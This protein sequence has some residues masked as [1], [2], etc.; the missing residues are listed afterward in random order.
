MFRA[1]A[2][3]ACV[4]AWT[5]PAWAQPAPAPAPDPVATLLKRVEQILNS[6]DR[7]SFPSLF[8]GLSDELIAQHAFDL[9]MPGAVRT[10]VHE[11]DRTDLEGAP[12]GDGYRVVVELFIETPRRAKIVTAGLDIRRP[13]GGDLNSWRIVRTEGVASVEGLFRLRLITTT[14]YAARNLEVRAEDL[15]ITLQ[16]G[17]VFQVDTEEGITGLILLGRGEMRFSPTPET[18]RGQLRIFSG[19]ETLT[20]PFEAAFLRL[21]PT[22]YARLVTTSALTT[23]MPDARMVRRAQ[24]VFA[25]DSPKSYVLG[26]QD[27]S[28]DT[29]HLQPPANDMLVEVQ[30]RRYGILTYTR[31]NAQAEDVQLFQRERRRTIALYASQAKL[32]ARGRFYSDDALREYDVIDYNIEAIVDPERQSLEARARLAIRARASISTLTLRLA[33][34]LDVTSVTSVE[35]GR[36]L[37]LRVKSQNTIMISLPRQLP[38]D[39]DITLILNYEGRVAPDPIETETLQPGQDQQPSSGDGPFSTHEP[40][41]LL[42]NRSLWYPQNPVPDYATATIRLVVP[43]GY[44]CVASGEPVSGAAVVSLRDLLTAPAGKPFVFRA[45]QPLRYLAFVVSRFDRVLQKTIAT[46]DEAAGDPAGDRLMIAV[47]ANA[48]QRNRARQLARP[49]EDILRFYTGL[50]GDAPYPSTTVAL[51][52]SDLPGGHSPGY[53]A[54]LNDPTPNTTVAWRNDPA[55]FDGFGEFFLAHEL[56]HQWWGQAIGWKN[57]HEQWLSEGFSQ[58]FAALYAQKSRGDKVFTDM[59]RQFR[60]WSLADSDQGPVHLGYRLGHIKGDTRVFRALVYNKGAA[61]LHML[62]R[63]LGDEVFFSSL[64]RFYQDRR[65]QKAGTEDLQRAFELESGRD[66]DRFFERWIYGSDLPRLTY[67]TTIAEREVTVRFDQVGAEVFDIPVTV[68]IVFSDGKTKDVI[69]PVTEKQVERRIPVDGTV[70]QVQINRDSAA[71]AEFSE[72]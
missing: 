12:P 4:L 8:S 59:L 42:S 9:F 32:A 70:R 23:V 43:E 46:S 65:F 19:N 25:R 35:Y 6:G 61:V 14:Q 38:Q 27:L 5:A 1:A 15:L 33:D 26:L 55:A 64:R 31:G 72:S 17:A 53:F 30:T 50:I 22:D 52:E 41:Y 29:W 2:L 51:V 68:T 58:Y 71:I 24:E 44:G 13:S 20:T 39:S 36:L 45:N 62:R 10:V 60:R 67:H 66:L 40:H 11:R 28:R 54:V 49:I 21:N 34:P 69:V 57:Y 47:E 3:L 7:T 37:H 16:D 63:L 56:A 18:E 48:R